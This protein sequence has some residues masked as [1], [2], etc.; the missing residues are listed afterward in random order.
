MAANLL[1]LTLTLAIFLMLSCGGSHS[2]NPTP[3][4]Q[5]PTP[6]AA[7]T[8]T[9]QPEP[10]ATETAAP[11]PTEI[12]Y[13]LVMLKPVDATQPLVD[14]GNYLLDTRTL[15]VWYLGLRGG[16]WSP[17]GTAIA[18]AACC[19]GSGAGVTILE[20]PSGAIANIPAGDIISLGWSPDSKRIAFVAKNAQGEQEAF[21]ANRDGS[22][23]RKLGGASDLSKGAAYYVHW[24]DAETILFGTRQGLTDYT[25]FSVDLSTGSFTALARTEPPGPDDP[26]ILTGQA[27]PDAQHVVYSDNGLYLWSAAN[28]KSM[29]IDQDGFSAA[30]SPGG[31]K[32]LFASNREG[33][34]VP[35]WR[36]YDVAADTTV[37]LP[38]VGMWAQWLADGRIIHDGWRCPTSARSGITGVPDITVFDPASGASQVMTHTPDVAEYEAGVSPDGERIAFAVGSAPESFELLDLK[39]GVATHI[40]NASALYEPF[41]VGPSRWSPDGRYLEFAYGFAHGICD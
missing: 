27:S 11:S 18:T 38:Q 6:S 17:D 16:A 29:L 1:R 25:Y 31:T 12:P 22:G 3:L 4:Q 14:I 34:A 15:G 13:D 30:W 24:R 28:G 21:V 7:S 26:R 20:I 36:L 32:L 41:H 10:T 2:T 33:E 23:L 8:S 19:I 39:T 40:A 5:T 35:F 9:P 37:D